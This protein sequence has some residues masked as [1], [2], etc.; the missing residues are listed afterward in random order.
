M[1][2]RPLQPKGDLTAHD[3]INDL[4][5][6]IGVRLDQLEL[7]FSMNLVSTHYMFYT[8]SSVRNSLSM[9]PQNL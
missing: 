9:I 5:F 6:R 8:L 7:A 1:T 2:A 4:I 3:E